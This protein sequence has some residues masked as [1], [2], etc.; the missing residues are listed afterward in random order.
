MGDYN[1]LIGDEKTVSE[2]CSFRVFFLIQ[3]ALSIIVMYTL[4]ISQSTQASANPNI[5]TLFIM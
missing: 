1:N 4:V 3:I 2:K 5:L